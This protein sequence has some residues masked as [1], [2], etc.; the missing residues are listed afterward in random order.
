M[1]V[2]AAQNFVVAASKMLLSCMQNPGC[3]LTGRS[4]RRG[5]PKCRDFRARR[6]MFESCKQPL[7]LTWLL[8]SLELFLLHEVALPTDGIEVDAVSMADEVILV[9]LSGW[10]GRRGVLS[11]RRLLS[12]CSRTIFNH[13]SRV[14]FHIV[15]LFLCRKASPLERISCQDDDPD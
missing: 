7:W 9:V 8:T 5:L 13:V 3:N 15:L 4:G 12:F 1:L 10:S 11:K 6:H 14:R 2:P